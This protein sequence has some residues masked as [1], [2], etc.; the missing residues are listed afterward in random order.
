MRF[1]TVTLNPAIDLVGKTETLRIGDVNSIKTLSQHPAGKGIN[2]AQVLR[3]LGVP[4]T[5]TGFLG[6]ENVGAFQQLFQEEQI[7]DEFIYIDGQ[8][9]T[10]IKITSNDDTTDLNFTGF[11]VSPEQWALFCE[12][13]QDWHER[14]DC[15]LICGSLPQGISAEMFTQ[16]CHQLTQQGVHWGL[17]TSK[18]A[19]KL[20]ITAKPILIKPNSEELQVLAGN[21]KLATIKDQCRLAKELCQEYTQYVLLSSGDKG[22]YLISRHNDEIYHAVLPC[23]KVVSTTGAGDSLLASFIT[24]F[25]DKHEDIDVALKQ[26]VVIATLVVESS[27]IDWQPE[28]V[29]D[30]LPLVQS[31]H[32]L[33]NY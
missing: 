16:W 20:A 24:F 3:K 2:V 18:S 26:A 8:T 19:L 22:A 5:A 1:L 17:D 15:V 10:N 28:D 23:R 21:T 27:G 25:L 7:N 12:R 29:K 4:V 9:R 11:Y 30:R 13:S 31:S 33:L 32:F 6:W 14:F